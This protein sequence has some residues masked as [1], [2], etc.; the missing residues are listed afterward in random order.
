M[1]EWKSETPN[2]LT[3]S[4][5]GLEEA[6][7]PLQY[8]EIADEGMEPGSEFPD[9]ESKLSAVLSD[10]GKIMD[11][12]SCRL[13]WLL[14]K[15]VGKDLSNAKDTLE[16]ACAMY[17]AVRA[18]KSLYEVG[19]IIHRDV[20]AGNILILLSPS[21][22]PHGLLIDWEMGKDMDEEPRKAR[23]NITGTMLFMSITL[24]YVPLHQ[25]WHDLES[26]YWVW[27]YM[28][29]HHVSGLTLK[30]KPL[31]AIGRKERLDLIFGLTTLEGLSLIKRATLAHSMDIEG[32]PELGRAFVR[33][34]PGWRTFMVCWKNSVTWIRT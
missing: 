21:D 15:E 12:R 22:E 13:D 26:F 32:C 25:A 1:I 27:V 34:G 31:N 28:I 9:L 11:M 4:R 20:S 24:E 14:F 17:D 7:D 2:T 33:S 23:S 10:V 29:I 3:T 30:G 5:D 8:D 6:E 18:H 16:F 19:R